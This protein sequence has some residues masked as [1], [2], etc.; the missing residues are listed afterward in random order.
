MEKI[1]G[2]VILMV[3]LMG[4]HGAFHPG[5]TFPQPHGEASAAAPRHGPGPTTIP[6]LPRYKQA[7]VETLGLPWN[8][9]PLVQ[10]PPTTKTSQRYPMEGC[11][12][13]AALAA[14]HQGAR[15]SLTLLGGSNSHF[16]AF[17]TQ[18]LLLRVYEHN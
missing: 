11:E 12:P 17:I 4:L 3:S 15:H 14:P 16:M 5:G 7:Q 2:F 6:G 1:A 13:S 10:A 9:N 8:Q 18:R